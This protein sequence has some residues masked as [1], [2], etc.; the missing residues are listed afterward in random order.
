LYQR[1]QIHKGGACVHFF[2][3]VR[4]QIPHNAVDAVALQAPQKRRPAR[5]IHL[6]QHLL[7][8]YVHEVLGVKFPDFKSRLFQLLD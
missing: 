2:G 4:A 1:A 3:V 6:R 7:F 5:R 8:V